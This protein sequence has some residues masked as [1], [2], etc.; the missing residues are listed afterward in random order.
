MKIIECTQNTP[1]WYAAR[2]GNFTASAIG[3][4]ITAEKRNKTQEKAAFSA[5]CNNLAEISGAELIPSYNNYI[6]ERGHELE[7]VAR[8]A[9]TELTGQEVEEVGFVL[10]D[11]E[12]FGCSPDGLVEDRTGNLQ[13]KCPFGPHQ[14]KY[15]FAKTLPGE[16]KVQCHMEMA[17]CG[18]QYNDFFSFCPG[19]PSMLYR[20]ERDEFTESVLSGL[21]RLNYEF[22]QYREKLNDDWKA[23]KARI[24]ELNK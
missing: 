1:E 18:T 22:D 17:V 5:I 7:P 6:M 11:A 9:Y 14:V 13:I 8:K 16:Y 24:E 21:L 23:E 10:H 4:W 15:I 3:L 19:L 20:V 12:G 2:H